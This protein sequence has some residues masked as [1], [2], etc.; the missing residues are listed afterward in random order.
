MKYA[1]VFVLSL[2]FLA[3][4]GLYIFQ[5]MP[6]ERRG[7]DVEAYVRAHI[8]E[9]SPEQAVLGGT[10]FVTAIHINE[11]NSTGYVEYEDGHIFFTADFT[12]S[13]TSE[14]E[15]RITSFTVREE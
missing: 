5:D 8:S 6:R 2:L 11:A 15:V 13:I 12:Y 14:G 7:D 3:L 10:F 4:V 9:L 1:A